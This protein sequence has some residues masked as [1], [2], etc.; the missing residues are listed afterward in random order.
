MGETTMR[1]WAVILGLIA[2]VLA[3]A[4]S[5]TPAADLEPA[6]LKIATRHVPP[7][8]IKRPDGSWE[9][10]SIELW[11]EI[12]DR[13][14]LEFELR[15]MGLQ[16]MLEAV[17]SSEVDAAVAAL[18][19]T[20][21]R[22]RQFDFSHP[23]LRSGLGIVLPRDGVSGWVA[24]LERLVSGPFVT[25]MGGLIGVLLLIGVLVWLFER[26]GNEQFGGDAVKGIGSAFWWSAVTMTTVGYGD[27]APRTLGGRALAVVWM[28]TSVILISSF[29]AGITAALTVGELS[30]KIQGPQDL[31][32]ARALT[33]AGST[34]EQF[35]SAHRHHY[36]ALPDLAQ[37]LEQLA[38]G[39]ADAVV[40]DAPILRYLVLQGYADRLKVLPGSFEPQ[41][42]GIGFPPASPLREPVNR[43]L[44]ELLRKP[45]WQDVLFRYLGDRS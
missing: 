10:L 39:G 43:Q 28:F 12:S 3:I 21:D 20:S 5:A 25:L 26:R 30:D 44:L 27:K 1:C 8:A 16:E 42:Y 22:E 29:T 35:L 7:F 31:G 11:Q 37:A 9:G 32:Q 41:D 40:Y 23:F 17:K 4:P 6:V 15:E 45:L 19:V 33:V 38:A 34:S 36:R 14:G 24:V 13:L 18:T 2:C